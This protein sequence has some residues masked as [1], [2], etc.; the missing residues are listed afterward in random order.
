MFMG[1]RKMSPR[2]SAAF[3]MVALGRTEVTEDSPLQ[4]LVNT[5]N[6]SSWKG[7]A[8][9]FLVELART[10]AIRRSL[11]KATVSGTRDEKVGMAYVLSISGD[12]ESIPYLERLTRDSDSEVAR[13]ALN[14]ERTLKAR[15]P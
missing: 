15:L 10:D 5:L 9:P 11:E 4:Y 3:A 13:A 1:E 14:A 8:Q 12:R 2:L 6:S 7:I